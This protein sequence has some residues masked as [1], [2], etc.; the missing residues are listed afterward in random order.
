MCLNANEDWEEKA[1]Q[2]DSKGGKGG[3]LGSSPSSLRNI[4]G[5][6]VNLTKVA[7]INVQPQEKLTG[8]QW[9][10]PEIPGQQRLLRDDG[11]REKLEA[12]Q[13]DAVRAN[14]G[15]RRGTR[16]SLGPFFSRKFLCYHSH[17]QRLS[18]LGAL[19]IIFSSAI[20]Q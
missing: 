10:K 7:N 17:L 20:R 16:W 9:P 18:C 13:G 1:L 5:G 3:G 19:L 8:G 4:P 2:G 11:L 15:D 14:P 6:H 12:E